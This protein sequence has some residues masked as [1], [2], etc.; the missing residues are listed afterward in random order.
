MWVKARL[1]C[2]TI[3][4]RQVVW[5]NEKRNEEVWS[6]LWSMPSVFV[7][8]THC[9]YTHIL[10]VLSACDQ[11]VCDLSWHVPTREDQISLIL[12]TEVPHHQVTSFSPKTLT[13]SPLTSPA[14]AKGN[15]TPAAAQKPCAVCFSLCEDMIRYG[16]SS[17]LRPL[18]GCFLPLN[19]CMGGCS[20]VCVWGG[21]DRLI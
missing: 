1:S 17:S 14:P 16:T 18:G 7:S 8:H 10:S 19:G 21:G 9:T 12:R 6:G 20:S 4:H 2:Y 13:I 15:P 11:S 5:L 3:T